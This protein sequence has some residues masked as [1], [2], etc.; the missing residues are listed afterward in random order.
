M[1]IIRRAAE[2]EEVQLGD[3]S[4]TGPPAQRAGQWS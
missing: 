2:R 1:I 4:D 3:G